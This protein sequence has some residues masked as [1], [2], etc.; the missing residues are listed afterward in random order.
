MENYPDHNWCILCWT[1]VLK[2]HSGAFWTK[3]ITSVITFRL[4]SEFGFVRDF[5]VNFKWIFLVFEKGFYAG[6]CAHNP[7]AS[8]ERLVVSLLNVNLHSVNI[9]LHILAA[10]GSATDFPRIN[11]SWHRLIFHRAPNLG[12][13][14][15][16]LPSFHLLCGKLLI[17]KFP[18]CWRS[19]IWHTFLLFF[20]GLILKLTKIL[21]LRLSLTK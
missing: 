16:S 21:T 1:L 15:T 4:Y 20:F 14:R 3:N 9:S 12:G 18:T 11:K 13:T 5:L 6:T 2:I 8:K 19:R 17:L 7:T 10:F